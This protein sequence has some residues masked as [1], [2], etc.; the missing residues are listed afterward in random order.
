MTEPTQQV[1]TSGKEKQPVDG[2]IKKGKGRGGMIM[3]EPIAGT[4][5]FIPKDMRVRTWLFSKFHEVAKKYG[6]EEYDA[7]ILE[8]E[9][10]YKR[11]AGEEITQQM[12]NFK[13]KSEQDVALR[14]EMTPSLAR[15]I[16]KQGKSLLMPVK[17]YSIPQCWRYETATSLR[18]REHYQWNMDIWGVD[19]ISA[20]AELL[21]AIA[22]FFKLVGLTSEDVGI[23]VSSRKI[24]QTVMDELGVKKEQFQPACVVVDKMDKL[25]REEV[26]KQLLDL[27]ISQENANRIIDSMSVKSIDQLA[28]KIGSQHEAVKE[29][30]TLFD[31]AKGYGFADYLIFD[32]SIVR[33]LSYYTGIVFEAFTRAK[34]SEIS[35]AICG[36]GR[37]DRIL[38]TYGAKQDTPACGFGFGDVV[39][40]E[41][42]K[43]KIPDEVKSHIINTLVIPFNEEL[44][45]AAC[46]VVT[47]LRNAGLKADIYLGRT[48]KIG[49]AFSYADRI[50]ADRAVL[51]GPDEW[52]NKSVNVKYLK[53]QKKGLSKK[54]RKQAAVQFT[55]PLDDLLKFEIPNPEDYE[56]STED[57]GDSS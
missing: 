28:E 13:D 5:D 8:S 33:G 47:M 36:G 19:N 17:W 20:E 51:I 32:A 45:P 6:F 52:A 43:D 40:L 1:T 39:I 10:L 35:R 21:A 12:Y 7:P 31:L 56:P 54:E 9:D 49:N 53:L 14:P 34:D 22:D 46:Q 30:Q 48:K 29:I 26:V 18:K 55:V 4:R 44:R 11:K 27:K 3:T 38:T 15:L 16:L 25:E 50:G 24:L 23:K 57:V 2:V 41:V 37:Y 42:L